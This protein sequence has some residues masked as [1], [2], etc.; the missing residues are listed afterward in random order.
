[1]W[2]LLLLSLAFRAPLSGRIVTRR[3]LQQGMVMTEVWTQPHSHILF[4]ACVYIWFKQ[5]AQRPSHTHTYTRTLCR[6]SCFL[7]I[8]YLKISHKWRHTF[9]TAALATV[10]KQHWNTSLFI[11]TDKKICKPVSVNQDLK[12][13]PCPSFC[14]GDGSPTGNEYL[15]IR[16]YI[17]LHYQN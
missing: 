10:M 6:S 15:S 13:T 2:C 1:M 5:R 17:S 11:C 4:I 8:T 12:A 3:G 16:I 14:L 7:Y 9:I